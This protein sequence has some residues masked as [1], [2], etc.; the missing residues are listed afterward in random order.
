MSVPKWY[1]EFCDKWGIREKSCQRASYKDL[2]EL[3]QVKG[4]TEVLNKFA[5]GDQPDGGWHDLGPDDAKQA[6][7]GFEE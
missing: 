1:K 3:K 7:K 5:Y 6:L 2:T 4:L